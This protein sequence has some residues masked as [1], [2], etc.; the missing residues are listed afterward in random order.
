MGNIKVKSLQINENIDKLIIVSDLHGFMEPLSVLDNI[1]D[2]SE[3]NIQIIA[4]GDYFVNGPYPSEV[5]D[6]VCAK[7]GEFAVLGNHDEGT[8]TAS[9]STDSPPFTEEGALRCLDS[10]QRAYLSAMPHILEVKWKSRLIRITHDT[11]VSG[12]KFAWTARVPEVVD[13]LVDPEVDLTVCAH[14]HYPFIKKTA[15]T[16]IANTGSVSALL[17]GHRRP[18]GT[19]TPKGDDDLF[20][21]VPEIYSTYLSVTD[22]EG[23]LNI[24]IERFQYDIDIVLQQLQ[25]FNHPLFEK[26]SIWFKTG[27]GGGGS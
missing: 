22:N 21:P 7:A 5:L 3:E 13:S 11:T 9:E 8:I 16:I 2:Q 12:D 4:G 15:G 23:K 20:V 6:W 24:A 19:I 18:D 25:D 17:L 14:T 26:F 1:L 10:G 27:V